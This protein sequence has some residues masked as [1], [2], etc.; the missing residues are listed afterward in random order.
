M[1]AR[2]T[3]LSGPKRIWERC[4]AAKKSGNFT[5]GEVSHGAKKLRNHGVEER[6]DDDDQRVDRGGRS[7]V[8]RRESDVLRSEE[9]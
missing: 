5:R 6:A 4:L 2:S 1:F 8:W 3:R 9:W 7:K